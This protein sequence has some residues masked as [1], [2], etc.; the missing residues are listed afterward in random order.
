MR[1]ACQGENHNIL[2]NLPRSFILISFHFG[3]IHGRPD[4]LLAAEISLRGLDRHVAKK[5]LYLFEFAG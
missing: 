3:I 2:N 1:H 5:E 4:A